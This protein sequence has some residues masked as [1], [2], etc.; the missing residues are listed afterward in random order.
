[1]NVTARFAHRWPT[2]FAR[3]LLALGLGVPLLLCRRAEAKSTLAL[4]YAPDDV[5]AAA[6]RFLR[7]DRNLPVREKDQNAGYVLFD[8]SEAGKTYRASLELVALSDDAGRVSTQA[9]LSIPQLP[10]RYEATLLEQLAA[11]VRDERGPP[12]PLRKP[13]PPKTDTPDKPGTGDA[14]KGYAAPDAG[15][16]GLPRPATLPS[17]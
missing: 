16:S 1:M 14:G 10:K 7:V 11:K 6:V 2:G 4:S 13:P 15:L 3:L 12:P 5:W 9:T 17:P 8:V